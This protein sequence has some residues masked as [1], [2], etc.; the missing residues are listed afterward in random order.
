MISTYIDNTKTALIVA[1]A[2]WVFAV[3]IA[4]RVG[5]I[6]AKII[7]PTQTLQS[8]YLEKTAARENINAEKKRDKIYKEV[9]EDHSHSQSFFEE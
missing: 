5:F 3:L 8:V 4:P 7:V 9:W 6:A 2:V 1:F